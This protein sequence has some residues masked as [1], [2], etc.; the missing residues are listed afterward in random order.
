MLYLVS[1]A[2][3][4]SGLIRGNNVF[5]LHKQARTMTSGGASIYMH[6]IAS[7]VLETQPHFKQFP[8]M[9]KR[10]KPWGFTVHGSE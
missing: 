8:W 10:L 5:I 6:I 4:R 1:Q 2:P 7:G 9:W 3:Q